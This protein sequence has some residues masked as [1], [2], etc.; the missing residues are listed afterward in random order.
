VSLSYL[1]YDVF[2]DA[3]LAGNQ[4]AVFPDGPGLSTE[5]MQ[6]LAREMNFAESTFI[7]PP[8]TPGTDVR[9]RIFTPM[10]EL[11]MAGH[12]T[13]GSTF[14]L[15]ETG[16]IRPGAARFVFGLGVGPTP[17]D[18][19]WDGRRLRF[20][21][22]TQLNPAF[23]AALD[24][25]DLAAAAVGVD[26][27]DLVADLP[28][29][30]ISCGLRYVLV[31]LRSR[32]A[33]DRAV[34]D[35]AA[36]RRLAAA[37]GVEAA[38]YPFAILPAGSDA[39]VT[40]ACSRPTSAS[41][42]IPRPGR[43]AG[44]SAVISCV[45]ASSRP[46]PPCASSTS[47]A[48]PWAGPAGCTS[49]FACRVARSSRSR[50]AAPRCSSGAGS[51]SSDGTMPQ[52]SR[53]EDGMQVRVMMSGVMAAGM[54]ALAGAALAQTVP[55]QFVVSGAA[56]E[57]IQDFTTINLATAERIAEACQRLAAA[58]GVAI[59]IM[60][61]DND[62]NHVY[63]SRMDGQGY[64]NIVTAEMKAQTALMQRAPS[65]FVMNQVTRDP[66]AELQRIQLGLFPN[67][68]GLPI[69]VNKQL[70]GAIGIGGSAPRVPVWSDEICG[71]KAMQEVLGAADV[72]PLIEDLPRPNPPAPASPAPVPRFATTTAPRT[73]VS[74]PEW[75]IGG[76]AASNV[77]NANQIS[78]A[79]A[80]KIARVCRDFAAARNGGMSLYILDT[81][82][83]IVHME[84]MDGQVFNN[85]RTA[86]LKA[87]TSLTSRVPTSVYTAQ[88]RNNPAGQTRTIAQFE[89]FTNSGGLPIVV[90]GQ[91]IG[92]IG[93]GGGA[94]GGGDE[95]CAV[96][97]LKAVFGEHVTLPVYP[98]AGTPSGSR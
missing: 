36:I 30:E 34:S 97:G 91:M 18:L 53:G 15:A 68:G 13:I 66:N 55:A 33:V 46:T 56:A 19:E 42:R 64:L 70:I 79:T 8:E 45:I 48:W 47:R 27:S 16:V 85:I 32:E 77:Y 92:A 38:L 2:T 78:L 4:L 40:R 84:R 17:V 96:E 94:G 49:P 58:E 73:S 63:S 50:W 88:G 87:Q 93:V 54:L 22:M 76:R 41:G 11:P 9:M 28:V 60:V 26:A 29:Q 12:P 98:A 10:N 25:R 35:G 59:T 90:D 21:W 20:A 65:K 83:E 23:G 86:L 31:P 89:F 72:P 24:A 69:V 52:S 67:S 5:R 6:A 71:H 1:H 74:N 14:A 61:I 80:K 81:S 62:G 95:N 37:A 57:R 75:V 39:T 3:P 51:C 43:Q 7:L 82:G 44:R